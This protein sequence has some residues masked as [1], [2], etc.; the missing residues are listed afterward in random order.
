MGIAALLVSKSRQDTRAIAIV[1][2]ESTLTTLLVP[3]RVSVAVMRVTMYAPTIRPIA[4]IIE[5][6]PLRVCAGPPDALPFDNASRR[7]CGQLIE[8]MKCITQ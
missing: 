5:A 2:M 8:R 6:L 4:G 7:L 3:G 1:M